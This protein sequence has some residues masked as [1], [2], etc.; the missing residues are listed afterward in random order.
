M[1]PLPLFPGQSQSSE[2]SPRYVRTNGRENFSQ[3]GSLQCLNLEH[4]RPQAMFAH[5]TASTGGNVFP[6]KQA[7]KP[8]GPIFSEVHRFLP[9]LCADNMMGGLFTD[10]KEGIS[11]QG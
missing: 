3:L 10:I 2:H 7:L 5:L 6:L 1:Q 11:L 9:K 4:S 8:I